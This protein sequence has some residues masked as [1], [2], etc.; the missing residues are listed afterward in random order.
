MTLKELSQIWR[1]QQRGFGDNSNVRRQPKWFSRRDLFQRG[2]PRS[3]T[4]LVKLAGGYLLTGACFWI[5]VTYG[6]EHDYGGVA[7]GICS[8][9]FFGLGC[10]VLTLVAIQEP[11]RQRSPE[12]VVSSED[13][14]DTLSP[15]FD[16]SGPEIPIIPFVMKLL[17]H[18]T[19]ELSLDTVAEPGSVVILAKD[20]LEE[21]GRLFSSEEVPGGWKLEGVIGAGW[22][23]MT[24][25]IVTISISSAEGE[26]HDTHVTIRGT[27]QDYLIRQHAGEKAT[28]RIAQQLAAQFP[29]AA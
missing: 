10:V 3:L 21:E 26:R 16:D 29:E 4:N 9:L 24:P 17:P 11:V 7:F 23:N 13:D 12:S 1:C 14:G 18:S 6:S 2:N 8:G 27:S 22:S 25:A 5:A 19:G 28:Q 15:E 20:I